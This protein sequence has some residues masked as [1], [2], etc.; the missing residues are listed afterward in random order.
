[1]IT[2]CGLNHFVIFPNNWKGWLVEWNWPKTGWFVGA[3]W[4]LDPVRLDGR[5]VGRMM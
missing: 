4:P 1:M 5:F 3:W 2:F